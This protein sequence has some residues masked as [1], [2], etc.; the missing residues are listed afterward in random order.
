MLWKFFS[1]FF[2]RAM[3][4]CT[5]YKAR[6]G[7]TWLTRITVAAELSGQTKADI[8]KSAGFGV[9]YVSQML[10]D[11]KMPSVGRL[12]KLCTVLN[13]SD[14]WVFSGTPRN[15]RLDPV[16]ELIAKLPKALEKAAYSY[17]TN[18]ADVTPSELA[19]ISDHAKISLDELRRLQII[20]RDPAHTLG[21]TSREFST[22]ALPDL[23]GSASDIDHEV[24]SAALEEAF[25]IEEAM[26]DRGVLTS[27]ASSESR[28][29]MIALLYA[30]RMARK[31]SGI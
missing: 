23:N 16:V 1:S 12:T 4:I 5:R 2:V 6:M 30:K 18:R 13:I 25:E 27:S 22:E 24:F 29:K 15:S 14:G 11:G 17:L 7:V 9:N 26:R 20:T 28:S 31:L 19:Q 21:V 3:L 10:K 8:S